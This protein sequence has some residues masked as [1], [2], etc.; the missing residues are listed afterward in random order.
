ME[1]LPVFSDIPT[2]CTFSIQFTCAMV[3]LTCICGTNRYHLFLIQECLIGKNSS[4]FKHWNLTNPIF[5]LIL[6][7]LNLNRFKILQYNRI[8]FC[9]GNYFIGE[10]MTKILIYVSFFTF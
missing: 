10:M 5:I 1:Y 4:Q 3:Y 8:S 6:M 9:I 7:F 2:A